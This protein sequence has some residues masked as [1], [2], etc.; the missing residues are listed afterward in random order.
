MNGTWLDELQVLAARF[1]GHGV[2]PDIAG[3]TQAEAWGV[4]VFLRR[5]AQ[6]G[7]A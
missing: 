4:F 6:G 7:D 5:I 1:S 3:L 2:G